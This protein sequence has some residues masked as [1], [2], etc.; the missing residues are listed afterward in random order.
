MYFL[1]E[2]NVSSVLRVSFTCIHWEPAER[3]RR[4][5]E[6]SETIP[7]SAASKAYLVEIEK[8]NTSRA[9]QEQ[10]RTI[11]LEELIFHPQIPKVCKQIDRYIVRG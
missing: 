10:H 8:E 9:L 3:V 2:L 7:T 11:T 6:G 4:L 5:K 1:F